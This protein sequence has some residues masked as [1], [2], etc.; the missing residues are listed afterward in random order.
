MFRAVQVS[1]FGNVILFILKAVAL[2][3]VNS[4]AIATDLG[5]TVVGLIVSVI[6]YYSVKLSNR[7]ADFLHNYGYGK[8]EHVCEALEGAVLIGIALMMSFQAFTHLFHPKEI[9]VP[10]LGFGFSVIGSAIN[11][12]G[13]VWILSLARRCDSPAVRAEGVHYQLEGFISLT[14]AISFL[15]TVLL[16]LTPL[17]LWAIYLDPVATLAVSFLI[18]PS[19]FRLAKHAFVKLLDASLEEKGKMEVMKQL[20]KYLSQCCEF[21]DVRSR[22]SGRNNFV[23]L[24]LVLPRSMPFPEAHRLAMEVECDLREEISECEATVSIVPCEEDCAVFSSTQKCPYL[25]GRGSRDPL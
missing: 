11:F 24:K 6:L 20:G 17:K 14:V 2:V 22:S 21:R 23:E 4:L 10:W 9:T 1:L 16:S 5:I 3:V 15:L 19:S 13:A 12:A 18:V 7:P 8:V 25:P